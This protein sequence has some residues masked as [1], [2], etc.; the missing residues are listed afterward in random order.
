MK[1]FMKKTRFWTKNLTVNKLIL[2]TTLIFLHSQSIFCQWG[3][4]NNNTDACTNPSFNVTPSGFGNI[5]E[6]TTTS[7][8]SNP[9]T[10]PNAIPGNMGC[11]LAGELN[12]TWLLITVSSSGT[13]EFSLGTPGTFDCYDWIMWPYDPILTCTEIQNNN[14]P[15]VAC[16]W[17]GMCDGFTGMAAPGNLPPLSDPSNFE[18]SL[19]VLA[20]NQ[21][22]LCFSNFS[23]A[24]TTIPLDF[25][26]TANVTCGNAIGDTICA[27]DTAVISAILGLSYAWDNSIPGFIGTNANGDTAYVNPTVTTSYPVD[28]DF[29]TIGIQSDTAIVVVMPFL[30]ASTSVTPEIC[31]DSADG[32]ITINTAAGLTPITYSIIGPGLNT[33]NQTGFFENLAAGNYTIDIVDDFGCSDQIIATVDPGPFCCSFSV[34][35]VT[36]TVACIDDCSGQL[37]LELTNAIPPINVEWYSINGI[38]SV[39]VGIGDTVYDLCNGNYSAIVTDSTLCPSGDTVSIISQEIY[40]T[41]NIMED[42]SLFAGLDYFIWANG[43]GNI[44]WSPST[45]LSCTLCDSAFS[46]ATASI[47]YLATITDSLGCK[48]TDT[49]NVEVIINPLFVPSGFSPNG[50]GNNDILQVIGGG[51]ITFHF[52]IFDKWGNVVFETTNFSDGWDGTYKGIDLP[53]DVFVYVVEGSFTNHQVFKLTGNVTLF[54]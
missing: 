17:N 28:I 30:N 42:T 46:T 26:G 3:D 13:L 16:N 35:I 43:N 15:P 23:A 18:T 37:Y 54:R 36:D 1:V 12:S 8:I 6:F 24:T 21:F 49:V 9:Q 47:Q 25:F 52:A 50:D 44:N 40:P 41:I 14:W 5:E 7:N 53:T 45:Y 34:N 11:L 2:L 32:T 19:N 22:M 4:C 10:N 48:T 31:L 33:S 27:G 20:G 51:T 38:F 29:G 39:P